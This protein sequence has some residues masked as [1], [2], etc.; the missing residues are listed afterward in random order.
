MKRWI[1]F[2]CLTLALCVFAGGVQAE[3]PP[4][5]AARIEAARAP[6][7][8]PV[9]AQ[10]LS[11]VREHL[12]PEAA[13]EADARI[14]GMLSK[15]PG[16]VGA[17][18][19]RTVTPEEALADA[20][21]LFD[22]LRCGYAGYQHLGGDETFLPL[23]AQVEA[24]INACGGDLSPEDFE[25]LITARLR[26]VMRDCHFSLGET[27]FA[28]FVS[29]TIYYSNDELFFQKEGGAY[30]TELDGRT[31][32]LVSAN[33][34]APEAMLRPTLD[35][36]GGFCY[37]LGMNAGESEE[38]A[39]ERTVPIALECGA[40][41][42]TLDAVLS[43]NYR[44][45]MGWPAYNRY[46]RDGL[47]VLENRSMYPE[48]DEEEEE[49]SRFTQ[50]ALSLSREDVLILDIRG[51][52][53]GSDEYPSN[54]VRNFTR[55]SYQPWNHV[56]SST[57]DTRTSI[58]VRLMGLVEGCDPRDGEALRECLQTGLGSLL[59]LQ[60]GVLE[61]WSAVEYEPVVE[62]IP[63]DTL[64]FVLIDQG[65]ASSGETFVNLLSRM[66]NVIFV[67]TSTCGMY[68]V[69]NNR[70]VSL[71]NSG[72]ALYCGDTLFLPPDLEDI[73]GRGFEP[74]LWVNPDGSDEILERIVKFIDRYDLRGGVLK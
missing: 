38:I 18:A 40:E 51:N 72:L 43:L 56:F 71:P 6:F 13:D 9:D 17:A 23:R 30:V 59:H 20:G 61:G 27:N 68:T 7:F 42:Q 52:S 73:E 4:E 8:A 25:A 31:W 10:K 49:L 34:G 41:A 44:S 32:R 19:R 11:L 37:A 67:G 35:P 12:T 5:L 55:L 14:A 64:V 60:M 69:A 2:A 50:D 33:G 46:E 62:R 48:S 74:D 58:L 65:V 3:L 70:T 39:M 26:P 36:D 22:Y 66:E 57:L 45:Y 28:S 15:E 29:E 16:L 24:D 63:S 53:G 47:T 54:W 1:F 21:F